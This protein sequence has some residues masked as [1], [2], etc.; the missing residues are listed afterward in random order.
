MLKL[1]IT[2]VYFI[3]KKK[4]VKK[5]MKNK[6]VLRYILKPILIKS[7]RI[8]YTFSVRKRIVYLICMFVCCTR[9]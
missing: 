4:N 5:S 6:I 9:L 2:K 7:A 8:L 1:F 3:K